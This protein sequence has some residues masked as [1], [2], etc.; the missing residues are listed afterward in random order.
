MD[1]FRKKNLSSRNSQEYLDFEEQS[2][3]EYICSPF[4]VALSTIAQNQDLLDKLVN[5]KTKM[6]LQL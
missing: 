1:T 3:E 4:R 2:R 6:C 5:Q